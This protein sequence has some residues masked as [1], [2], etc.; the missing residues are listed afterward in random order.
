MVCAVIQFALAGLNV[1][2]ALV[3]AN[4]VRIVNAGV[5][6]FAFGMGLLEIWS[7]RR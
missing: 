1:A 6:V 5:A 7:D 2:L 4:G 3:P